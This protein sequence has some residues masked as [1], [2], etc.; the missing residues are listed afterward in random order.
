LA[1]QQVRVNKIKS[2][3]EGQE[4]FRLVDFY[5]N[6]YEVDKKLVHAV[7]LAES[8]YQHRATSSAGAQGLMQVMPVHKGKA[9]CYN[10]YNKQCNIETGVKHIAGLNA[11]YK[12]DTHLVLA[13]YN[14]GGG[15]VD[16]SLRRT[17]KIPPSTKGYVKKVM[18]YQVIF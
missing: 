11:K 6:K 15:A 17:G 18:D 14:A 5:S 13:A 9:G 10:L 3:K 12:G 4:I 2:T 16:R 8:G 1:Q 7:I